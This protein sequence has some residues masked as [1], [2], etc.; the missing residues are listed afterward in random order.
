MRNQKVCVNV[1][2]LSVGLVIWVANVTETKA[3]EGS[4]NKVHPTWLQHMHDEL[5]PVAGFT[6]HLNGCG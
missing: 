1:F 4:P 5:L 3:L 2:P 6:A